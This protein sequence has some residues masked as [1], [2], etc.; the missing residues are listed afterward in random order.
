MWPRNLFAIFIRH[1]NNR[2]VYTLFN[3]TQTKFKSINRSVINRNHGVQK[4]SLWNKIWR[5]L[6]QA[7]R[8]QKQ[9]EAW[10]KNQSRWYIKCLDGHHRLHFSIKFSLHLKHHRMAYWKSP[11]ILTYRIYWTFTMYNKQF[12]FTFMVPCIL[13]ISCK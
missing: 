11:T 2:K 10:V 6:L 7:V 3:N 5:V 4:H 9:F 12:F 8:L 1:T 13:K